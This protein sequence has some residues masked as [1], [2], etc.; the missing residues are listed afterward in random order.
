MD[1]FFIKKSLKDFNKDLTESIDESINIVEKMKLAF[2][3]NGYKIEI[4]KIGE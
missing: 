2:E 4:S 1:E 3:R